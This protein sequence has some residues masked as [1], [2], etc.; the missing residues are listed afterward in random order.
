LGPAAFAAGPFRFEPL[1]KRLAAPERC[2]RAGA[3]FIQDRAFI[4]LTH[5]YTSCPD[6]APVMNSACRIASR[7]LLRDARWFVAKRTAKAD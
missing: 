4:D 6:I 1:R 5:V 3:E 7:E 2:Q